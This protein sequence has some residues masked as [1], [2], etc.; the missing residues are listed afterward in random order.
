VGGREGGGDGDTWGDEGD[1][2]GVGGV[3]D[4]RES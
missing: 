1:V 2:G 3:G 4:K